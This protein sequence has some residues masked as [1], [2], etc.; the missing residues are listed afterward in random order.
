[1]MMAYVDANVTLAKGTVNLFQLK[2]ESEWQGSFYLS[3]LNT[4]V[5]S[6]RP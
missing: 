4:T 2:Q 5:V 6:A 1:M 3:R